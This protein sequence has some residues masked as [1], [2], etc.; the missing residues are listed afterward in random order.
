MAV[1][2]FFATGATVYAQAA[3]IEA[4]KNESLVTYHVHHLFHNVDAVSKQVTCLAEVDSS[5]GKI[6][7]V[8]VSAEVTSFNSGNSDRDDHAM[9]AVDA[10]DYPQVIFQS[11][12]IGYIPNT[13][14]K[15]NG[16]LTFRGVTKEI[17]VSLS[18]MPTG[19]ETAC[20][21]NF[22]ISLTEF[23]VD[24]PSLLLISIDDKLQVDFHIV[25]DQRS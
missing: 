12:S 24:R 19:N 11:D 18:V 13:E 4:D 15:V 5:V 3:K 6:Q 1:L 20:D 25:F 22:D 9:K 21:G 7:S 16:K 8:F 17:A 14:I 10:I 23:K 2:I